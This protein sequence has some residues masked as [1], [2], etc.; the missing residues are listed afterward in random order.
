MKPQIRTKNFS[1][2]GLRAK[3]GGIGEFPVRSIVRLGSRTSTQEAFPKSYGRKPIVEVNTVESIENSRDKLRMKACFDRAGVPHAPWFTIDVMKAKIRDNELGDLLPVLA[4]R[5]TG[6]KG[7][8]MQKLDNREQLDA[9]LRGNT[10]GY[11]FEEFKNFAREYRLHCTA[12]GCFMAWRKLRKADAEQRWFFNSA[13]CNW[14][15][16]NHELYNKPTNFDA[17]EQHCIQALE[18]TGLDIGSFDVRIQSANNRNPEYI[19]VEV[20]S[21]PSLGEQGIEIYRSTIGEIIKNKI[22]NHGIR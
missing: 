11:Y 16:E 5:I 13:N 7:H 8:G 3:N 17:I 9:F 1:S 4:K 10:N 2:A 22:N 14:V 19:L 12:N 6:F 18:A 21:A 15:G 20:N